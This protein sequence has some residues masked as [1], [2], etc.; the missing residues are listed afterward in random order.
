MG[1]CVWWGTQTV[2]SRK[3]PFGVTMHA[4]TNPLPH[5]RKKIYVHII[6]ISHFEIIL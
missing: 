1:I 4:S 3:H 6:Q 5:H 2:H